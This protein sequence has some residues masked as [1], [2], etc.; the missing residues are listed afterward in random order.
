VSKISGIT[1]Y[2]EGR[3]D[4]WTASPFRP[5]SDYLEY[6]AGYRQ[7]EDMRRQCAERLNAR[8][9]CASLTA[10]DEVS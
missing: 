2:Q 10:H 3:I 9:S 4:G 6:E 5:K 8:M 1:P 7:G